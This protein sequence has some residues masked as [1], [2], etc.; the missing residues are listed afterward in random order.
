M[1]AVT[2]G[3]KLAGAG[4]HPPL[5]ERIKALIPVGES[6]ALVEVARELR[7]SLRAVEEEVEGTYEGLC[8]NV[9]IRIGSRVARLPRRAWEIEHYEA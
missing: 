8:L 4:R 2:D 5:V 9:G 6:R 3:K 1:E 7:V